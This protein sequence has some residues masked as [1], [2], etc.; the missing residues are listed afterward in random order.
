MAYF[1]AIVYILEESGVPQILTDT[2]VVA[3]GSLNGFLSGKHY[4]RCKRLHVLLATAIQILHFRNFWQS[5]MMCQISWQINCG[6][7]WISLHQQPC[8]LC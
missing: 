4:N 3:P 1:G 5:K 8:R 6:E 7:F 2:E